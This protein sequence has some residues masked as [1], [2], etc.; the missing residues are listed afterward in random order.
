M[1][2]HVRPPQPPHDPPVAAARP[3]GG[4]EDEVAHTHLAPRL[5]EVDAPPAREEGRR[6]ET[7]AALVEHGDDRRGP[8]LRAAHAW[9]CAT[10]F[11]ATPRASSRLVAR[12]SR[13]RTSGVMPA[14]FFGPPPP[15]LRPL[16]VK[17]SPT[18][19]S[20]APPLESGLISWK[21]PLPNVRV[22]TTVAR[23]RSWSAPVT[24]SEAEADWPLTSTVTG[25]FVGMEEPVASKTCSGRER[26]R[27]VTILPSG[28]KMEEIWTASSSRPP[29]LSR[30]SS[31]TALAPL[32]IRPRTALF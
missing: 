23:W 12:S 18:V 24:I 17:Y 8:A 28:M 16:G 2:R 9:P 21:T 7:A 25:I 19:M 31:T 4:D 29:P 26:P 13:A 20:S 6:R 11:S 1:A 10:V 15:R 14:P 32:A 22:P 30:R 3:G 5:V 27:V